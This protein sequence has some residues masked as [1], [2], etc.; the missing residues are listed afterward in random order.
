MQAS[1]KEL[2]KIDNEVNDA[3]SQGIAEGFSSEILVQIVGSFLQESIRLLP[4]IIT[5]CSHAY[6]LFAAKKL[7]PQDAKAAQGHL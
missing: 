5:L 7:W 6:H 1:E 4:P 3:Y 2:T